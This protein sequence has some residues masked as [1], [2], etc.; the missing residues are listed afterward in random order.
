M[1]F[2]GASETKLEMLFVD[3]HSRGQGI[4]KALLLYVVSE[5][6]VTTVD[7]NEQNEQAVGFYRHEGFRVVSRRDLDD[8][9]RPYPLLHMR[10]GEEAASG[11]AVEFRSG[12]SPGGKK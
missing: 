11:D 4:G 12:L 8:Q 3:S 1:G 5:L 10:I 2:V 6:G 9:G 7:V